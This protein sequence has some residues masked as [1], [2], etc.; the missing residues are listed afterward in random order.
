MKNIF[1]RLSKQLCVLLLGML[2]LPS[3]TKT[4]LKKAPDEDLDIKKVFSERKFAESFLTSAYS[5]IPVMLGAAD[6]D[7]RNPFTGA[8]D[9]MEITFLGAYSHMLNSGAWSSNDYF[10]DIWGYMYEGIRKTNIFLENVAQVPMPEEDRKKWI[11]EATFLRAFFHFML[12]RVYGPIPI[13]DHAYTLNEDYT[14]IRRAPIDKV[15]GFITSECDKSAGLLDWTVTPDKYGRVTKAAAM[16]L[17]AQ[18]LLY[19]ASPLWNGNPD[20]MGIK[21][22][23]GTSLFPSFDK[24]RWRAAAVA[25]K[26]CIDGTEANGYKLYR[27]ASN[28]PVRNYQEIFIE[29]NN[30][31]VLFA[32]N[33]GEHSHFERCSNPISYGGYSIF[34]P[35]QELVDD[36]EMENGL[37]PITGYQ[38]DGSPVINAASG[39]VETGYVADK[40]PKDYYP[41]GVRNMYVKREPRFYASINFNGATWKGRGIQFWNEG[42]DGR[43]RAGSDYCI[44]GYLMKKMVNPT[45]DIF[46][47]RFSLNT[48]IY[49]RLG[50]VY[51]NYAEALNEADGP[52]ADVYQYVN[53]IRDR[54]GLPAL[55]AGLSQHEM[56]ERI[57]HERRIEL[58]FETHRYFDTHR[59]KTAGDI[60]NKAIHGMNI[61]AGA[62]LNDDNFYKRT[63][64]EKRV[65]VSPK[66]YLWPLQQTEINKNPNL[67]QNPGW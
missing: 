42:L 35:T 39:Y 62:A 61:G 21:D 66:H 17:K 7:Q 58:A 10:P 5:N 46:Q 12:A 8:C 24:E 45:S 44:S 4:Y 65:F 30:A 47:N 59:W 15:I 64:I 25:A 22:K 67:V 27:S 14:K 11:G 49:Y 29:R 1:A 63:V 19:M 40:H 54:S 16:A 51:L 41:A 55:P 6:W 53:A 48:W 56:R 3:C 34:C 60:D 36:Y 57:H 32:R 13:A 26:A 38:P 28:D 20:Y 37:R 43:R 23:D 18:A 31:E 33:A 52:V 9:E 50:E 2:L